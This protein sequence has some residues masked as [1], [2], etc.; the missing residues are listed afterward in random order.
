M[1]NNYE[2]NPDEVNKG[3][4]LKWLCEKLDIDI[5]ELIAFGD[6]GNDH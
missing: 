6:G 3:N 5:S 2:I 4:A 1:H